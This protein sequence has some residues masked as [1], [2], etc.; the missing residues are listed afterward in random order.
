LPAG[1]FPNVDEPN[2]SVEP[3]ASAVPT[4]GGPTEDEELE[5]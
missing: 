2:P 5:R 4:P 3:G 1:A